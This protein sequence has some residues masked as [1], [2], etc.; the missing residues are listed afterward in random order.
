MKTYL[1]ILTTASVL[2]LGLSATL[3]AQPRWGRS[4][5]PRSGVCFYEDTNFDG[6]YFCARPGENVNA[7]PRDMRDRIS[8]I[9]IVGNAEVTVF[10]DDRFRGRSARFTG[11][12]RNLRGE[13]WNDTISSV[14]VGRVSGNWRGDRP[15]VWG[16][17]RFPRE[18]A[19]FFKDRDFRGPYFCLQRGASYAS[20]P[21][22]FNDQISS[23]RVIGANA[24][25]FADEDFHGRTSRLDSD[26]SNLK[27]NWRDRI[28]SIRVF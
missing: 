14:R 13:G 6:E 20:M 19:C 12:I 4:A 8:S 1:K 23:V 26:T 16:N 5:E 24:V 17:A 25:I 22:G 9:R 28:S 15:P 27:G 21:P 7:L 10:R 3:G 11:D 18:G 2:A